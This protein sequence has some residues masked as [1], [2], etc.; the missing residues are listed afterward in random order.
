VTTLPTRG[1][2][3]RNR[4]RLIIDAAAE[5]FASKGYAQVSM[6]DVADAVAVRPSAL[7]RHFRGKDD[8]LDQVVLDLLTAVQADLHG[9][10]GTRALAETALD[11]R[12][13]G[14]LWQRESRH[15]PP[16]ARQRLRG[17]LVDIAAQ[18]AA[19]V[20]Q[21]RPDLREADWDLLAWACLGAAVSI[22]FQ[23]IELPRPEYTDLLAGII[24]R[25][26]DTDLDTGP[27]PVATQ[28][29][30]GELDRRDE[31]LAAAARLFAQRGYH[32]VGVDDVGAAV[33]IAGPSIYHHFVTKLDL[34]VAVITQ[35]AEQLVEGTARALAGTHDDS[36][37]LDALLGAYV[38][39]S[40]THGDLVDVLITEVPHLP[41]PHRTTFR[42][43]QRHYLDQWRDVLSRLHPYL[44]P[45]HTRVYLQ[46]GLTVINDLA[47]TPHLRSKPS[48]AAAVTA[49]GHAILGP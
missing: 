46:A 5:L 4:R 31:L 42:E 9:P 13:I 21:R 16:A 12:R 28:P 36:Q 19:F 37:A 20:A 30:P 34:I 40:F 18:F 39:F 48:A 1:T 2:R 41:E 35:G 14:V 10:A 7:Y 11:H 45:A 47:R 24:D 43:R 23:R 29:P 22:S 38:S 32:S 26:V 27:A 8:L 49:I 15:L 25:V 6:A 33:G 3:P 17:T 44:P